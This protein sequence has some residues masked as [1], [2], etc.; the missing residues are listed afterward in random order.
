LVKARARVSEAETGSIQQPGN[1]GVSKQGEA[2]TETHKRPRSE[3]ST[4]TETVTAPKRTRDSSEPGTCKEALTNMKINIFR[5]TY[6]EDK[7]AED[8]HNCIQEELGR[9]LRGTSIGELPTLKSY[10]PEEGAYI[11][12]CAP[13]NNLVK[14][15]SELLTITG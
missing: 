12:I 7:L 9:V 4:H 3:G 1:A 2:S 10:R 15:Y 13:T 8:D 5:E 6:P 14:G 11:Y